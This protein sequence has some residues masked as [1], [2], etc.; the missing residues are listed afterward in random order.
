MHSTASQRQRRRLVAV[1]AMIAL[2]LTHLSIG[3]AA[4]R[5][6][7]PNAETTCEVVSVGQWYCT[8]DGKGYYCDTNKNP[9]K[10]KNCRPARTVP[11]RPKGQMA[12]L[13][14]KSPVVR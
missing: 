7:G 4:P 3:I 13:S 12:P 6:Q 8:I 5:R 11:T 14:P 9:D 1:S 10:N 2:M